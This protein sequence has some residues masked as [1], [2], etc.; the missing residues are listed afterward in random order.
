MLIKAFLGL[1]YPDEF[2]VRFFFKENLF[3]K[4]GKV[5][6]LGAGNGVNLSLFFQY[7]WDITGVDL[8]KNS[9]EEANYNFELIK[10]ENKLIN[11]YSFYCDDMLN[12]LN[13][14]IFKQNKYDI[15]ILASSI[16]YLTYNDIIKLFETI[17]E[18]KILYNN[19]FCFIRIRTKNDYR[20]GKGIKLDS[21]SYRLTIKETGEENCINTFFEEDEILSLLD[22]YIPLE[23]PKKMELNFDNYQNG[24]KVSNSD[25]IIWGQVKKVL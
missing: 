13:K 22:K 20:Y 9:I 8:D 18:K 24:I 6:E 19:S 10:K 14:E 5:L 12:F 21:N 2:L 16:Y 11:P 25:L 3:N 1:K 7:G 15:L 17:K 4:K 23:N